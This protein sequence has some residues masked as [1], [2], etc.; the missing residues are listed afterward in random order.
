M[1]DVGARAQ[2]RRDQHRRRTRIVVIA[3]AAAV[4]V[5]LV[6]GGFLVLTREDEPSTKTTS[7]TRASTTT[8]APSTTTTT[9]VPTSTTIVPR[10]PNPVVALAQQYDGYY[11]GTWSNATSGQTG[12]A[13]LELR[14]DPGTST[15]GVVATFEGDFFGADGGKLP[16]TIE[17]SVNIGDPNA[18]VVT[19]TKS[20]GD[21][22]GRLDPSLALVLDAP[23]VPDSKVKAF[24]MT[25]RLR[26]DQTG[27]DATYTVTYKNGQTAQG[28]VT[29]TCAPERQRPSEVPTLCAQ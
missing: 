15:I 20:F 9:A 11:S 17:A 14:I 28:T 26:E 7:A 4:G 16:R 2:R 1:A 24:S 5:A 19:E 8:S 10:S 3:T 23:A 6:V 25:G 27:F 21:V 22:T 18:A 29:T 13:T 12:P